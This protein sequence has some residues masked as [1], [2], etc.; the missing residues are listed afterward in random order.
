MRCCCTRRPDDT[1]QSFNS[2]F[3]PGVSKSCNRGGSRGCARRRRMDHSQERRS[4]CVASSPAQSCNGKHLVGRRSTGRIVE[5]DQFFNSFFVGIYIHVF[6][7]AAPVP[8]FCCEGTTLT[9]Y[10]PRAL[11]FRPF[12]PKPDQHFPTPLVANGMAPQSLKYCM[13]TQYHV[14]DAP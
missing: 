11:R 8:G 6:F 3:P 12:W 2:N 13:F 10:D 9:E 7:L 1:D 14:G 5:S 4:R